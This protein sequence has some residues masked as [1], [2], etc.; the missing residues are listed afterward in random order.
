MIL[1]TITPDSGLDD[2][3]YPEALMTTLPG[4]DKPRR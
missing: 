3:N 1:M 2:D 4:A